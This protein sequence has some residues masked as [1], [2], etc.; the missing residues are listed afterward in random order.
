MAVFY[1]RFMELREEYYAMLAK[2]AQETRDREKLAKEKEQWER[3]QEIERLRL[4]AE[5]SKKGEIQRRD[6][7]VRYSY[8]NN[9]YCLFDLCVVLS[10]S[11]T[12]YSPNLEKLLS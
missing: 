10:H 8:I 12:F 9:C 3:E 7:V 11:S 2:E 4:E 1:P 6:R 5:R